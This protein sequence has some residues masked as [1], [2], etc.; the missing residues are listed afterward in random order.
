MYIYIY[1]CVCMY[2]I[3]KN[4]IYSFPNVY[5]FVPHLPEL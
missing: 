1:M 5:S 2:Y 3:F 4:A